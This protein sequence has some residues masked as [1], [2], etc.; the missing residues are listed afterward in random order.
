MEPKSPCLIY[1]TTARITTKRNGKPP[2]T[3][4]EAPLKSSSFQQ[5]RPRHLPRND[6]DRRSRSKTMTVPYITRSFNAPSYFIFILC[7]RAQASRLPVVI[8]R[9]LSA[10]ARCCTIYELGINAR[11][12]SQGPYDGCFFFF[13]ISP[14]TGRLESI[15]FQADISI[16][17]RNKTTVTTDIKRESKGLAYGKTSV[18]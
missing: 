1:T 14:V 9:Y 7:A 12:V 6:D 18:P 8:F 3:S 2:T 17:M 11:L 15:H 13:F 5:M 10:P 4:A 16:G